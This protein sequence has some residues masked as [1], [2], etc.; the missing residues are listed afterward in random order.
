MYRRSSLVFRVIDSFFRHWLLFLIATVA[1]GGTVTYVLLTRDKSYMAK[2]STQVIV[3]EELANAVGFGSNSWISPAQQNVNRFNDM[4]Q[5]IG[6]G[7][8]VDMF[9]KEAGL[10]QPIEVDPR[11]GMDPRF[12]ALRKGFF[13]GATSA[14]IFEIGLVWEDPAECERIVRAAQKLYMAENSMDRLASTQQTAAFLDS[15]IKK[16]RQ[17]MLTAERALIAYKEQNAGQ[18]PEA[19]ATEIA[20]L[21]DLKQERDILKITAQDTAAR[22]GIIERRLREIEPTSI[23]AQTVGQSATAR[24][25]EELITR[26]GQLLTRGFLPTSDKVKSIELQIGTLEKERQVEVREAMARKTVPGTIKEQ[27]IQANPEYLSLTEQ[28]TEA[29]IGAQTH[30]A[31]MGL[32]EKQIAEYEERVRRMPAAERDLTE[33]TRDYDILKGQFVELLKRREQ[34]LLKANMEKVAQNSKLEPIG[35][36][37]PESTMGG[38]KKTALIGGAL[39]LGLLVG[40]MLVVANEWADPT[41]RYE[42]D[43]ERMLGLPVLAALPENKEILSLPAPV[44]APGWRRLMPGQREN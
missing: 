44:A 33:K 42:A 40:T 4:M 14:E 12:E 23:L 35:I 19:Q 16:Y 38:K 25:I 6:P 32:L 34:A 20:R 28:L 10:K 15:E 30:A 24:Q 3:D 1:V 9:L 8:F 41:I 7:G 22:R 11:K 2:A 5:D 18:T 29:R 27:T 36:I 17:R 31:R 21:S 26:R 37:Y 43:A 13:S 39:I